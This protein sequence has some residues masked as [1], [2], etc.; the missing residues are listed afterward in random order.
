[1]QKLT[2]PHTSTAL[3][4]L[5]V[6]SVLSAASSPC[7]D[8]NLIHY[9]T[10]KGRLKTEFQTT[11]VFLR[12]A[13]ERFDQRQTDFVL[14]VAVQPVGVAVDAA[15]FVAEDGLEAGEFPAV[16]AYAEAVGLFFVAAA[17]FE[18]GVFFAV[19]ADAEGGGGG[20]V[21]A[22]FKHFC[23]AQPCGDEAVA[24]HGFFGFA[25]LP[26]YAAVEHEV[27]AREVGQGVVNGEEAAVEQA[28]FVGIGKVFPLSFGVP[29]PA[30]FVE[31][32]LAAHAVGAVEGFAAAAVP[33][34]KRGEG[35]G[36]AVVFKLI[37]GAEVE[38]VFV[39]VF[40]VAVEAAV[41]ERAGGDAVMSF[42]LPAADGGG[43]VFDAVGGNGFVAG[44]FFPAFAVDFGFT[45]HFA[46]GFVDVVVVDSTDGKAALP[47]LALV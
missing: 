10:R 15:V 38:R 2:V 29:C 25:L 36:V 13:L 17:L 16:R 42:N 45:P 4:R 22:G 33:F 47:A 12:P 20:G 39:E 21:E 24:V 19:A 1:M 23:R 46:A 26:V 28:G 8:L 18:D 5:A 41:A 11:F 34:D 9:K 14:L 27:V 40:M 6:L 37:T 31:V 32:P 44:K 43:F 3:P 7:P 30:A 35:E